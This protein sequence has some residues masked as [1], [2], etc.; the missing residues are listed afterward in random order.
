MTEF[1]DE[2]ENKGKLYFK[3]LIILIIFTVEYSLRFWS[4]ENPR[5]FF[6]SFFSLIDLV[7]ILPLLLGWIDIR[8]IRLFRWFRI[9]RIIRFWNIE[10]K[11]LGIKTEDSIIFIRIFC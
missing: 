2:R 4:A 8:F 9:L 7:A 11:L 5:K 6:F 3:N 1:S 10:K